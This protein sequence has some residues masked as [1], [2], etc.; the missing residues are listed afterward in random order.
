MLSYRPL[1]LVATFAVLRAANSTLGAI[2]LDREIVLTPLGG[3]VTEVDREIAAWQKRAAAPSAALADFDRL[4]WAFVAKARVSLDAGLFKLA[5]KTAAVMDAR[6][7]ASA[8]A[9]FLRGHALHNLHHFAEAEAIGRRLVAERGTPYDFA[10]LSDVLLERGQTS[11]AIECLQRFANLKPGAEADVRIAQV[12]WL[13]GD[14]PG[15]I[16]ALEDAVRA[17]SPRDGA[18]LAWA[19]S[20]LGTLRLQSGEFVRAATLATA[21]ERHQPG[22]AP[23][24]LL[25]GRIALAQG[26]AGAAVT[27]LRAAAIANPLPEYQWWL[28][29][30]LRVN[31]EPD[32]AAHV[33]ETLRQHGANTDPRTYSLFLATRL[34]AAAE[35][36]RLAE[37]ERELR[38]DAHTR[39]AIAWSRF[40]KGDLA[41]AATE[42]EAA[43]AGAPS[44]PRVLLHAAVIA[45]ASHRNTE[46]EALFARCRPGAAVLLPS[47]R[48]WLSG[49]A[50]LRPDLNAVASIPADHPTAAPTSSLEK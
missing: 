22:Y 6:F 10:L 7:G 25:R 23:A 4:G 43:L 32:A 42:I 50:G 34:D 16:R 47:E 13:K 15:A 2:D 36:V 46:A 8:E 37:E 48:R 40:A 27:A 39:D 12:R 17:T 28:A 18:T 11:E 20:R 31:G 3:A 19:L 9:D 5:E 38:A 45:G 49:S 29:D 41:G 35:A 26:D 33:E 1:V 24:L 44:D 30:A 21:A 14:L